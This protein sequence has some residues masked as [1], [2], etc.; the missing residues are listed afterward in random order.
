MN[1]AFTSSGSRRMSH[2]AMRWKPAPDL[3]SVL[4][5]AAALFLLGDGCGPDDQGSVRLK[6]QAQRAPGGDVRLL[7]VRGGVAGGLSGLRFKWV[8]IAGE[9]EAQGSDSPE[10]DFKF[11]DDGRRD[12]IV[13]EAWR[14]QRRVGQNEI[15]V[16]L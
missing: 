13:G 16:K 14:G 4:L 5:G 6:L 10:T 9:C 15:D 2:R 8:A 3:T 11:G 12:R 1:E 7:R